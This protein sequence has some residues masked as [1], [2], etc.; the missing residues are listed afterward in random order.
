MKTAEGPWN[1]SGL[2][3]VT[4]LQ[5]DGTRSSLKDDRGPWNGMVTMSCR[6]I[7]FF[8][9]VKCERHRIS[10]RK[11]MELFCQALPLLV[12]AAISWP[13]REMTSQCRLAGKVFD[14]GGLGL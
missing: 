3:K 14:S 4:V 10:L 8:E 5:E 2:L 13:L 7:F 6:P 1:S 12:C 11:R 9:N